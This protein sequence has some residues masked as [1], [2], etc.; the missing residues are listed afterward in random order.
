MRGI[1]KQIHRL[2][3]LQGIAG[4]L[5]DVHI[6]AQRFGAAGNIDDALGRGLAAVQ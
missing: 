3:G 5:K 4:F 6:A 2:G 1:R